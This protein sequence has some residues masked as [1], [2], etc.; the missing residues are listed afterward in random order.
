M[1][2]VEGIRRTAWAVALLAVVA[3]CGS[4]GTE[5]NPETA[6]GRWGGMLQAGPDPFGSTSEF[7]GLRLEVAQDGRVEGTGQLGAREGIPVEGSFAYPILLLHMAD[8][9]G[10]ELRIAGELTN[11]V[12]LAGTGWMDWSP[13]DSQVVR[14]ILARR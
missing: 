1:G 13:R 3:G 12:T 2:K 10:G 11:S 9:E 7:L 14:F 8:P 4:S 5:P 6:A